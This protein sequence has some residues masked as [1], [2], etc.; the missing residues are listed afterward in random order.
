MRTRLVRVPVELQARRPDGCAG[1]SGE[2]FDVREDGARVPSIHLDADP[3]PAVHAI[4]IDGGPEMLEHLGLARRAALAYVRSLPADEPVL[5]ATFDQRLLMRLP[6]SIDRPRFERELG[7]IE[8]GAASQLWDAAS[9]LVSYLRSQPG[10]K[11]LMIVTRGCD[12]AGDAGM[13][14]LRAELDGTVALS[15]FPFG[16]GVPGRCE[17]TGSDPRPALRELARRSAGEFYP[18]EGAADLAAAVRAIRER[19]GREVYLAYTPA[20]FGA[21]PRDD[22]RYGGRWRNVRVRVAGRSGCSAS[23]AGPAVRCERATGSGTCDRRDA[24][25]V[26]FEPEAAGESLTAELD[27]RV[28]D[29]GVVAPAHDALIAPGPVVAPAGPARQSRR[30]VAAWIPP[31]EAVVRP[32]ARPEDVFVQ[33]LERSRRSTAPPPHS[34][35]EAPFLINGS[36]LLEQRRALARGLSRH[37]DWRTWAAG[38]ARAAR[39]AVLDALLRNAPRPAERELLEAARRLTAEA[40]LELE[41]LE[42]ERYLGAWLGDL[43]VSR[44]YRA[45]EA[46]LARSIVTAVRQRGPKALTDAWQEVERAWTRV[47]AWL[48]P[49]SDVRLLGWLVPGYDAQLGAVGYYR[50][51][52]APP[53]S[54]QLTDMLVGA[55]QGNFVT[56]TA[57][58]QAAEARGLFDYVESFNFCRDVPLGARFVRWMLEQD[59]VAPLLLAGYDVADVGYAHA[60]SRDLAPVL[61]RVGLLDPYTLDAAMPARQVWLRLVPLDPSAAEVLVSAYFEVRGGAERVYGSAP[62]CLVLGPST[63]ASEAALSRGLAEAQRRSAFP[64][65]LPVALPE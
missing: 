37:P 36:T 62:C 20:P 24:A 3:L 4:L 58:P 8:T 51:V 63:D 47:G 13:G 44:A 1:L 42:I 32:D 10:R 38:R 11:V 6:W 56:G 18:A 5:L 60:S 22:P 31:L 55:A 7:W 52:L 39:L 53:Y 45:C 57:A 17:R 54:A 41:P 29:A 35:T 12:A 30:R 23:V 61:K 46:W 19:L 28:R 50:V 27:D 64:Y 48:P 34:W 49:P 14:R 26:P 21:G 15:V 2:S 33:A 16:I 25:E 43:P 59:A 9:E 40:P 65:V